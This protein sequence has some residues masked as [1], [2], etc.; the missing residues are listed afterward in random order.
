MS[1]YQNGDVVKDRV[2]GYTGMIIATVLWLNGCTRYVVQSQGLKK[3]SGEPLERGEFDELQLDLVE[4][5]KF[6]GPVQHKTGGPR[7]RVTEQGG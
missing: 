5:D 2:T 7:P 4:A 6:A 1:K 3:D